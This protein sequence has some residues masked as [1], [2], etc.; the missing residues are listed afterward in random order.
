MKGCE[1]RGAKFAGSELIKGAEANRQLRSGETTLAIEPADVVGSRMLAFAGIAF[2]AAGDEVAVGVAA[3]AGLRDD[4]VEALHGGLKAAQ[5]VEAHTTLACIDGFA[6]RG[7]T[8][9]VEFVEHPATI[10]RAGIVHGKSEA[11]FVWE[12]DVH[13]MASLGALNQAESTAVEEAPKSGTSS[14]GGDADTIGEP[15]QGETDAALPF[16]AG[17]AEQEG[18]DG[19]VD[20]VEAEI[21]D[22]MVI[23]LF[24]HECGV[25]CHA[26]HGYD[27][28]KRELGEWRRWRGG[29][30][31]FGRF[32]NCEK[33]S[34]YKIF[35][36]QL[37]KARAA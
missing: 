16:Q 33:A 31:A 30:E 1:Q 9:E 18:V 24:P 19:A 37:G 23:E 4:V 29:D 35:T 13:Q 12:T 28:V 10:D 15:Q 8:E 32:R 7:R 21:R 17:V 26:F 5:A 14:A 11:D 22:E 20:G 3:E 34:F 2:D 6:Q 25:G 27:P 36:M